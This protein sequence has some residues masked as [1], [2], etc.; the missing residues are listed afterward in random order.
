MDVAFVLMHSPSAGPLTWAPVAARLRSAGASVEVPS[1]V[2]VAVADPPFW[3]TVAAV[4]SDA[5]HRR[6]ADVPVV[7][8]A[9]SNAGLF[10]PVAVQAARRPVTGCLF[11]DAALPARTGSTPVAPP[12]LLAR[13][14]VADEEPRLP[15]AYDETAQDARERG[16]DVEQ[17]A[18][19]HL[20]QLVDPDGVTERI[21]SMSRRWCSASPAARAD[22]RRRPLIVEVRRLAPEEVPAVTAVLGVARLDQ[23]DGF[24]LVAWLDGE[25]VGH[26]HLALH[27]PPELQDVFVRREHR[28]QGF[29]A[30]L[31]TAAE[32]AAAARGHTRLRL[33]VSVDAEAAQALYRRL[34]YRDTALP[35]RRVLGTVQVRTG[36][37]EVDDTLLTWEKQLTPLSLAS[38][39]RPRSPG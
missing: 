8:V 29:A 12:D 27:D 28:G 34:G 22:P 2:G 33:E 11:V 15:L 9:H 35:P 4:V 1:L 16:W 30:A 38:P 19:L 13:R 24:Y 10:V 23:G 18:G 5:V 17:V 37:L 20:H 32:A 39:L 21:V 6:P 36:P 25:P 3:P 14:A 26:A 31:T 7:L